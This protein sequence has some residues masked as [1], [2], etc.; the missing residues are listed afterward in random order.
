MFLFLFKSLK[1]VIGNEDFESGIDLQQQYSI[2][3]LFFTAAA[4]WF[5]SSGHE[6]HHGCFSLGLCKICIS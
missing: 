3:V 2:L 6:L 4:T 1:S 5:R